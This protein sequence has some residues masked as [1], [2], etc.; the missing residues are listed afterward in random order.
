[1][2]MEEDEDAATAMLLLLAFPLVAVVDGGIK[3]DAGEETPLL[4][5]L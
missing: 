4:A 3:A 2:E 1:M 5:L